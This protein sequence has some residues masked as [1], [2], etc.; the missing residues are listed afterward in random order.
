MKLNLGAGGG[1]LN[2]RQQA[3]VEHGDGPVLVLAG[4]GAGKTRV[5]TQ[6][7]AYLMS[8]RRVSP[9]RIL[10]VT[11]T[12]KAAREM[13]ERLETLVGEARAQHLWTG[14]FH[15]ICARLLRQ[16]IERLE[17]GY[18]RRFAIYDPSD[19]EKLMKSVLNQLELDL[20]QY[21]PRQTLQRISR[22]KNQGL[23][24]A[25]YRRQDLDFSELSLARIYDIYQESLARN[26]ALD[27]DDLLLLPLQLFKRHPDLLQR[28][29]QHFQ[30]IL[31]DEYQDTNGVQFELLRLLAA[32]QQNLFVVGDVDQSIYS[33][34][35][36]DFQIILRF[37]Q[38]YPGAALIKLEENYRSTEPILAAA[39]RLIDHNRERFDKTLI[40]VRGA[41][42]PLRF[43]S[44]RNEHQEADFVLAQLRKLVHSGGRHYGEICV[45]YRTNAQS[46]LFEERLVQ[47]SI[48]H[49]IVGA[50]R[51]YERKE[52][53]DLMAYL[54]VIYNPLDGIN[55]K[56]ILNTPKRGLGAKTLQ[57]LEQ[58]ATRDGLSLWDALNTP[59]V[60]SSLPK[61][62]QG[63]LTDFCGLLQGLRSFQGPLT[64]LI[65]AIYLKTGYRDELAKDED[66]F[67]NREEYV[68]SFLQAAQDF[69]PSEPDALLGDFLQHLALISDVDRLQDQGRLVRLM[70]VH[71]AKGL[72]FPVVFVTGLEEG[73]FPHQRSMLAEDE[74]DD[75]PIEEERRL[76][77]VAMTR[78]QDLLY[79]TRAQQR[80][81][82]GSP[83]YQEVSRF[84]EEIEAHLPEKVS[85]GSLLDGMGFAPEPEL[86]ELESLDASSL[87]NGDA[88]YHP[89]F[90]SGTVERVYVSGTRPIAIVNFPS[91]FGKRILDLRTAPL[92][93]LS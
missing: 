14:T 40:S 69:V 70:T 3:A 50:F 25:D 29:Q 92:N 12:N 28:Y 57:Q 20:T 63:T 85:T 76:M 15:A 39:N 8:Q 90:G 54:A 45:L 88:V 18:Q 61:R 89:D 64:E 1:G 78:A 62:A 60:L 86:D 83:A 35:N 27:F 44:A 79:L 38:D 23:L 80:S 24:P 72:E 30:Y 71:A 81:Q 36:A 93:K 43:H 17:G 37:Q 73:I 10:V 49:Q 9:S 75:G 52:I 21:R 53:K 91:G 33:F 31:V 11:F 82:W 42:E 84:L 47:Q 59:A 13:K 16:E 7:A 32:P 66:S 55:L 65:E 6:R 34:R 48:P 22:L 26:N 77:Y 41:G 2:Q 67:E 68:Q 46:R 74:G 58:A 19:Q 87:H 5:L 4:A 56:R 51:F